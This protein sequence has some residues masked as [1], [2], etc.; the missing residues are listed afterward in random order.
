[1]IA[2]PRRTFVLVHGA[3]QA[4]WCWREVVGLL[5][6]L[7]HRA[8][9]IDLPG[10]GADGTPL[11]RITLDHYVDA[12]VAAVGGD[13]DA[14]ILVGH[15][16]GG[17]AMQAADHLAGRLRAVVYVA[18]TLPPNGRAMLD[19][20]D[21]FDP[22]YLAQFVWADDRRSA[23][24]SPQGARKYLYSLSPPG[25]VDTLLPLLTPEPLG[26]FETPI[27]TTMENLGRVPAHYVECLQ[28]RAVPIALQRS[29]YV[30]AGV[31]RI[32]TLDT[33][34]SPFFSAP[35]DLA[36]VLNTIALDGASGR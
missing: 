16:L 4:S 30:H 32:H 26:P 8:V 7:G 34:H 36:D 33:D 9:A 5:G 6:N 23:R 12:I 2:A 10:H 35:Q 17:V 11:E 15:S 21:G 1:M 25:L 20:I 24:I 28:D 31:R 19:T 13:G 29:M 18:A 3:W 14:P 22:A 27:R